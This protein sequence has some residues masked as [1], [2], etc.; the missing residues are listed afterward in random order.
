MQ[1][2]WEKEVE[3]NSPFTVQKFF[4]IFMFASRKKIDPI[5]AGNLHLNIVKVT[6]IHAIEIGAVS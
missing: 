6:V 5:A 4:I 3:S 1:K 2:L